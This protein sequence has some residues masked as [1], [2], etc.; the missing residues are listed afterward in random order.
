MISNKQTNKK[1]WSFKKH[2]KKNETKI[3]ESHLWDTIG[4]ESYQVVH[5]EKGQYYNAHHDWRN[6]RPQTRFLTFLIYL[7]DMLHENAGGETNFPKLNQKFHPG[8]GNVILFYD[9]MPDG[10]VDD[11]TL[12]AALP[13]IE[14]EKWLANMWIWDPNF[15]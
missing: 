15:S 1:K 5:Y 9:M 13:V 11:L 10:N 6:N 14:G 3:N 4:C 12:H 7:S 2:I 8:K